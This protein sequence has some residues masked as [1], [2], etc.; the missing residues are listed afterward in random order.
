M[1]PIYDSKEALELA[2]KHED[3]V[4]RLHSSPSGEVYFTVTVEPGSFARFE[5]TVKSVIERFGPALE[6]LPEY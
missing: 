3:S 1:T 2:N 4:L 6:L 5:Q